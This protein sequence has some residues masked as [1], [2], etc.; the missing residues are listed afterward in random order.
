MIT[1]VEAKQIQTDYLDSQYDIDLYMKDIEEAIK[2]CAS[3]GE[4][5]I[6]FSFK[7]LSTTSF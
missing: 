3:K 2:D 4:G 1:D 7:L 6:S 5:S